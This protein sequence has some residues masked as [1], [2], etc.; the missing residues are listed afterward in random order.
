MVRTSFFS[1]SIKWEA[2]CINAKLNRNTEHAQNVGFGVTY[3]KSSLYPGVGNLS[4]VNR[5]CSIFLPLRKF[6][7]NWCTV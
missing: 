2:N 5:A 6:N 4:L 3:Q 7:N 1:V